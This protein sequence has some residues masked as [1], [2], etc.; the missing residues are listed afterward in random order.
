MKHD[1]AKMKY[2]IVGLGLIG[3]SVARVLKEKAGAVSVYAADISAKSLDI[4]LSEGI[5]SKAA[6]LPGHLQDRI[7]DRAALSLFHDADVIFLCTDVDTCNQY[8]DIISSLKIIRDDPPSGSFLPVVTDVCSTKEELA[9]KIKS[10]SDPPCFV[11]GHPM[12]GSERGGY[13]AGSAHLFENA[14]YIISPSAS[15]T[16]Y[17]CSLIRDFAITAGAIPIQLDAALHDRIAGS[18]SHVP[19]II[20]AALV[21]MVHSADSDG[22]MQLIAAG[23][24]RDLTRIASSNPSLWKKIVFSNKE[25]ILALM[26]DFIEILGKLKTHITQDDKEAM[27]QFFKEARDF[28]DSLPITGKSLIPPRFDIVA[29]VADKPGT[30]GKIASILGSGGVNIRNINVSNSREF[31]KGCLRITFSDQASAD[32]SIKM[33]ENQGYKVYPG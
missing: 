28:R 19:H 7:T 11:G 25:H 32:I 2:L 16:E 4:A 18:V 3:G 15:S 14:Y 20:A 1:L 27:E 8:L 23:G 29:D 31:E 6:L 13:E 12:T 9:V 22:I 21:N 30:I 17:A 26:D 24:F 10:M 33:L 5:I